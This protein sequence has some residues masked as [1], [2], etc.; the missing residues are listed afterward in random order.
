MADRNLDCILLTTAPEFA[1][2]CGVRGP[3]WI[4][5]TRPLFLVIPASGSPVAAVPAVFYDSFAGSFID[6]IETWLSPNP[7]DEGVTLIGD[8]LRQYSIHSKRIGIQLGPE[9]RIDMVASDL[10][11]LKAMMPDREFVDSSSIVRH[12]RMIKSAGEIAKLS[13]IGS[14]VSDCFE[15]VI[16]RGIIGLTEA[17]IAKKIRIDLLERG[18]DEISNLIVCSGPDGVE[19]LAGLPRERRVSFGDMLFI[20]IGATFDGYFADFDRNFAIGR[21]PP[22]MIS[23]YRIAYEATCAGIEAAKPG[24]VA[25]DIWRAMSDV[26]GTC[27]SK[28]GRIGHGIGLNITEWPS[29]MASDQTEIQVGMALAI[30]PGYEYAPRKIMLHEENIIVTADGPTLL[31]RRASRDIPI[32]G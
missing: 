2:F 17:Q 31:S 9:T 12:L 16:N 22:D 15:Q 14:V 1:Y 11:R 26:M 4:S 8:L 27:G 23:A 28:V 19:N 32:I 5:P 7:D 10:E 21:A 6:N 24:S 29:I 18:A 25:A 3:M 13:F 30:E 20:D